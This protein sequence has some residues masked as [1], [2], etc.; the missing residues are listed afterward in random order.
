MCHFQRSSYARRL[1]EEVVGAERC[2]LSV[3]WEAAD[4]GVTAFLC[5][6]F[7]LTNSNLPYKGNAS[8]SADTGS[9]NTPETHLRASSG[10]CAPG[11]LLCIEIT[12]LLV[13]G[14]WRLFPG[15]MSLRERSAGSWLR[16]TLA[17]VNILS[18][19]LERC[20]TTLASLV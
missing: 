8:C 17:L 3:L 7:L 13:I 6:L 2:M 10:L 16:H 19:S 15:L 18:V 9:R 4:D 1:V 12:L 5:L 14:W 20:S 11:L